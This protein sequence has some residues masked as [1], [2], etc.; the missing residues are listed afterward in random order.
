[1]KRKGKRNM[2]V[3]LV[4]SGGVGTRL[5]L[6]VPKQ[7]I[8]VEGRPVISYSLECLYRH[9]GIDAIQ[10]VAESIW[11]DQIRDWMA[12]EGFDRKFRG[13]S[14]PGENRQLSIFHGL[15][16]IRTFAGDMDYVFIHDAARPML[17]IRQITDCIEG[18]LGHD[19][20][21]P[22]LPMKDTVYSSTDGKSVTALLKRSEIYAGQAPELFRLGVYYEANCRLMPERIL[23]VNGSTE[24]AVMAGLDVAMIPGDEGNFKITTKEDLERFREKIRETRR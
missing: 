13:F 22:V 18:V 15:E 9:E 17:R 24:P 6:D 1:M 7:Y 10:I 14:V 19:G 2:V 4:L 3:A 16:D 12:A 23:Q 21:L 11:Q 5:G 20:V 8:E